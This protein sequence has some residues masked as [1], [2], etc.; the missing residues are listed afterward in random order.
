MTMLRTI[1]TFLERRAMARATARALARCSD[2]TLAD[3]GLER[4]D[5]G[6]IA[7]LAAAA[8]AGTSLAALRDRLEPR[9]S[10]WTQAGVLVHALRA[11]SEAFAWRERALRPEL[12]R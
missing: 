3:L 2:R 7:R 12:A 6:Q 11:R 1:K 9:A 5:I 8:P 10:G 4:D